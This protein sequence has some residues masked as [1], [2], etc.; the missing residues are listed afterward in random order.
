MNIDDITSRELMSILDT[1]FTEFGS[2][3]KGMVLGALAMRFRA[4]DRPTQTLAEPLQDD[5]AT[6]SNN[7]LDRPTNRLDEPQRARKAP[8]RQAIEVRGIIYESVKTACIRFGIKP[9]AIYQAMYRKGMTAEEAIERY[10]TKHGEKVR[11]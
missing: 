9:S 11:V 1:L 5:E 3:D 6:Q 4:N 8:H 10:L 2:V 7:N